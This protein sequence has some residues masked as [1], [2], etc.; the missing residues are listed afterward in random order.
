MLFETQA[1]TTPW[2][3]LPWATRNSMAA[4]RSQVA[5]RVPWKLSNFTMFNIFR[6]CVWLRLVSFRKGW[7]SMVSLPVEKQD[8]EGVVK[9]WCVSSKW[10]RLLWEM[11]ATR[12][13]FT[14][15]YLCRI[16]VLHVPKPPRCS[17]INGQRRARAQGALIQ[18]QSRCMTIHVSHHLGQKHKSV[19]LLCLIQ[20]YIFMLWLN[21][22]KLQQEHDSI[23]SPCVWYD[24]VWYE[25]WCF[26]WS[27]PE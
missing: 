11:Y 23:C 21:K 22:S 14:Y 1:S 27:A 2:S 25:L 26:I 20:E 17:N 18:T 16:M 15:G 7:Y 9:A 6:L 8:F 4:T 13:A 24:M 5:R 19:A 10:L 3:R 12:Y